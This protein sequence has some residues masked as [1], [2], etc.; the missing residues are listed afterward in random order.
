[1]PAQRIG[2]Y[3]QLCWAAHLPPP[4]HAHFS[5][6]ADVAGYRCGWRLGC[7]FRTKEPPCPSP[8]HSGPKSPKSSPNSFLS[9]GVSALP[10]R[11]RQGE[12]GARRSF[13]QKDRR[14]RKRGRGIEEEEEDGGEARAWQARKPRAPSSP[15]T[16]L[17]SFFLLG[18]RNHTKGPKER[19]QKCYWGI[20]GVIIAPTKRGSHV[21]LLLKPPMRD[22]GNREEKKRR[23]TRR[24]PRSLGSSSRLYPTSEEKP[25]HSFPGPLF[26]CFASPLCRT[27]RGACKKGGRRR[28]F[29]PGGPLASTPGDGDGG[30]PPSSSSVT[31][32]SGVV[33]SAKEERIQ[34]EREREAA[35]E[36]RGDVRVSPERPRGGERGKREEEEAFFLSPEKAELEA[37]NRQ[38]EEEEARRQRPATREGRRCDR[39]PFLRL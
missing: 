33:A 12:G 27:D 36:K 37:R 10:C 29:V 4:S 24:S 23:R 38:E 34:R 17:S 19:M 25:T 32:R 31:A 35:G 1:M 8:A 13:G 28:V 26:G 9:L 15:L 20:F 3:V 21:S 2:E 18:S 11:W 7:R 39:V 14:R 16:S 6:L 5:L 30:L 22:P